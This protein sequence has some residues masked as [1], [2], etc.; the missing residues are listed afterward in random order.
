M[1]FMCRRRRS[2]VGFVDN[3]DIV[4]VMRSDGSGMCMWDDEVYGGFVRKVES[5]FWTGL[6]RSADA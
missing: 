3:M 1:R 6:D 4:G 5:Y 2:G